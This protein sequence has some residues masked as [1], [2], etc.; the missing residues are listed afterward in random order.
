LKGK[1]FEAFNHSYTEKL[2]KSQG[3]EGGLAPACFKNQKLNVAEERGQA[4]LPHHE[5]IHVEG[6]GCR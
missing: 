6:L 5:L 2:R 3:Q 4:T 1:V